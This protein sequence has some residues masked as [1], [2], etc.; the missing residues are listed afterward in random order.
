[1]HPPGDGPRPPDAPRDPWYAKGLRF[2]CQP[3]C[4]K[5]CTRH[6]EYDYVYLENDDV[7]RLAA[8]FEMPIRAFRAR[9]TRKDDG[10]TILR[11]AGPACPFLEGS[12]CTVY[13]ARPTQCATF[14]FWPEHLAHPARWEELRS[15]CPG[16]G[17]GTLVPLHV[18]EEHLRSRTEP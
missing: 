17:E 3:D 4:G 6:G 10:H 15:F 5:C 13:R 7:A 2:A 16:I 12:A 11:M 14:P 9:Y 1:M 18:I 8:H